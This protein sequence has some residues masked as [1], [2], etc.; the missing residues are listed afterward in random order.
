MCF[1]ETIIQKK[2]VKN[3]SKNR[4]FQFEKSLFSIFPRLNKKL[5]YHDASSREQTLT[6]LF[7]SVKKNL[8]VAWKKEGHTSSTQLP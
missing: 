5:E 8:E 7:E 2:K 1:E 4:A 6:C 3:R